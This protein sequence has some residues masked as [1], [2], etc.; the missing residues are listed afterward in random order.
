[1]AADWEKSLPNPDRRTDHSFF[2]HA[3]AVFGRL[4]LPHDL[5]NEQD[6]RA[7]RWRNNEG[8]FAMANRGYRYD[9]QIARGDRPGSRL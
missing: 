4:I 8:T 3:I 2:V 5:L 6:G 9:R 1:M 7:V